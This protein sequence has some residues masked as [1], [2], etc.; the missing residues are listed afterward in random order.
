[1][2]VLYLCFCFVFKN[3]IEQRIGIPMGV[4]KTPTDERRD[5]SMFDYGEE[6]TTR[7]YHDNVIVSLDQSWEREKEKVF[8]TTPPISFG[9]VFFVILEPRVGVWECGVMS[10]MCACVYVC[11]FGVCVFC[12]CVF[13]VMVVICHGCQ[14]SLCVVFCFEIRLGWL[15]HD[16]VREDFT[17]VE[18]DRT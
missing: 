11:V 18:R 17:K 3:Q 8:G 4:V 1:M 5:G 12:A 9:F 14:F 2:T 7:V 15:Y 6:V 10:F 13:C 16:N